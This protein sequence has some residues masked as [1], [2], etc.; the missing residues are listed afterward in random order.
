MTRILLF[1][2]LGGALAGCARNYRLDDASPLAPA[3]HDVFQVAWQT[4]LVQRKFLDFRPQEWAR[5]VI[6]DGRVLIGSSAGRFQAFDAASGQTRWSF[7]TQGA[8]ASTPLVDRPTKTV[9][10]GA[11]DGKLYALDLES[12]K[13]RWSYATQGTINAAPA[14]AEGFILFTS[15]EG[16]IYALDAASGKWRWQYD[17]EMP[18]GFT[19]QGYAGVT[20]KGTTA[21][22]GF[23]DGTLVALRIFSGDVVCTRSLKGGKSR[24]VDIDATPALSDDMLLTASYASG[25]YAVSLDS[26][27]IR[28]QYP[29]EGVTAVSVDQKRVYF[30]APE[31]GVVALDRTGHLSWRQAMAK[32]VP[33]LAVCSGPYLFV[34]GTE[35]GLFA[36][37]AAHGRLL[38][39]FDPGHGISAAPTVG[40]GLLSTLTNQGHLYLFRIL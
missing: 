20:V 28:W 3:P 30:T 26:G 1:L 35:S 5:A 40:G 24:F 6:V 8:I 2:A 21:F 13:L 38:Q 33:S 9:Y 31:V 11:D 32:G 4:S 7:R 12:G 19:I 10:V 36:V 16:R 34:T 18:E 22:T 14:L 37:D 27:S 15:S 29:V 17:R 39:Y 25:V 23:A